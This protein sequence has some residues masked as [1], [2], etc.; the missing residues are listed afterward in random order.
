M[1]GHDDRT[2]KPTAKRR[3]EARRKGQV[4]KSTDL[5]SAVALAAGVIAIASMGSA[6]VNGAAGAMRASFAQISR[7]GAATTAA[8]LNGLE[9]VVL[10]T[11]LRTVAPIAGIC[12]G[13]RSSSQ[14]WP[15]SASGRC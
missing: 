15:R 3:G 6:V 11:L 10:Q 5:S 4:A 7:P 8:G 1:A 12:A 9:H 14:T 2:E 13:G